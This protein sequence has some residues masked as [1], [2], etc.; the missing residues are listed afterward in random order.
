MI[1][2]PQVNSWNE[3]IFSLNGSECSDLSYHR[4]FVYYKY[5]NRSPNEWQSSSGWTR[6]APHNDTRMPVLVNIRSAPIMT[7]MMSFY[8]SSNEW[9]PRLWS[10]WK[11]KLIL[12]ELRR[13]AGRLGAKQAAM[14][15][16]DGKQ[17]LA[18][19]GNCTSSVLQW[20]WQWKHSLIIWT[21]SPKR[22]DNFVFEV[23]S[24]KW[25]KITIF[26]KWQLWTIMDYPRQSSIILEPRLS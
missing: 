23:T 17:Q 15:D 14:M 25:L 19:F 3:F 2:T 7:L 1:S 6:T 16:D 8:S 18:M 21:Q 11:W 5:L 4:G 12:F 20:R 13:A 10:K 24:L 22:N 26:L 9:R